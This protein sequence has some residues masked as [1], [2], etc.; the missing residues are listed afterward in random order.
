LTR[1]HVEIT[2]AFDVSGP[3]SDEL[4][5]EAVMDSVF[6]YARRKHFI[7]ASRHEQ[8][9]QDVLRRHHVFWHDR[10]DS[11]K[12]GIQIDGREIALK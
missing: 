12:V 2:I 3:L 4:L 8:Q 9:R 5:A 1:K 6:R 10:L 7:D 11:A